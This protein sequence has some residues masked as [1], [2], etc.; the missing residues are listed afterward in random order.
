MYGCIIRR[1]LNIRL[2]KLLLIEYNDNILCNK[3]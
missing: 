2:D 1:L 3:E